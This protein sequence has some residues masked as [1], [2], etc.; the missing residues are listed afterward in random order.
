MDR[1]RALA[2]SRD[3]GALQRAAGDAGAFAALWMNSGMQAGARDST[4]ARPCAYETTAL[5][6]FLVLRRYAH[7]N[8]PSDLRLAHE[9]V[10]AQLARGPLGASPLD[11]ILRMLHSA[12]WRAYEGSGRIELDYLRRAVD[13]GRRTLE[14]RAL[15]ND[16]DRVSFIVERMLALQEWSQ[17]TDTPD[18][19]S[20]AV[21]LWRRALTLSRWED[22]R[23]IALCQKFA[24]DLDELASDSVDIEL[25]ADEVIAY[26]R[27]IFAASVSAPAQQLSTSLDLA[28]W[29]SWR[30]ERTGT[31]IDLE[32]EITVRRRIL[33]MYPTQ[34]GTRADYCDGLVDA[35]ATLVLHA[36]GSMRFLDEYV[37]VTRES[38]QLR[39]QG[40]PARTVSCSNLAG[41][42]NLRL[43]QT[44]DH[45]LLVEIIALERESL[46]LDAPEG[47]D[48]ATSCNNL[49]NYLLDLY[50]DTHDS[51]SLDEAETLLEE[52]I[53]LAPADHVI[54]ALACTNLATLCQTR[55]EDEEDQSYIIRAVELHTKALEIPGQADSQRAEIL[56]D[57]AYALWEQMRS[58]DS[59]EGVESYRQRAIA[60]RHEVL[61]MTSSDQ[62]AHIVALLGL[63]WIEIDNSTAYFD[64]PKAI[65]HLKRATAAPSVYNRFLMTELSVL[66]A[67]P[68]IPALPAEVMPQLLE[69]YDLLLSWLALPNYTVN[70]QDRLRNL[71]STHCLGSNALACA[72]KAED[73]RSG[74]ELLEHSRALLW[75]HAL[76]IRD[77]EVEKLPE[78]KRSEMESVRRSFSLSTADASA[79][80]THA[81]LTPRDLLHRKAERLQELISDVRALPGHERFMRG[82]S[83]A[84]LAATASA[85]P[86]VVLSAA[87][88]DADCHAI[89]IP[90]PTT[91]PIHVPILGLT[92][93]ELQ[94]LTLDCVDSARNVA[95]HQNEHSDEASLRLMRVSKRSTSS[96]SYRHLAVLW[97]KVVAPILQALRLQV[98]VCPLTFRYNALHPICRRLI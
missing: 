94:E 33:Q 28:D 88:D 67:D 69:V 46:L 35:F 91:A 70:M 81:Y 10:A 53:R 43:E 49:A 50:D 79:R 58:S 18:T 78:D 13:V 59:D 21:L 17:Q 16:D 24:A 66:L 52:A 64:P 30:F 9:L 36:P 95:D 15:V 71:E 40:D 63:V 96:R 20:Q 3:V 65:E 8:K 60:I 37:A 72:L 42:L 31:L 27:R 76:N 39:P 12:I 41:A 93:N 57:L 34:D 92:P 22:E 82:L 26:D 47:I 56:N 83:Y 45:S 89:V 7:T 2:W 11:A 5:A 87:A 85:G 74:V 55:Y 23:S 77:S 6:C 86:V 32:E 54:H 62:P 48:R 84:D 98:S 61:T 51:E 73:V 4:T 90:S 68:D 29:L 38:L 14:N 80:E 19:L 97:H 1:D 44:G 25:V 75:L